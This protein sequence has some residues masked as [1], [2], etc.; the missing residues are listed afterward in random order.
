MKRQLLLVIERI[1]FSGRLFPGPP[2]HASPQPRFRQNGRRVR[3]TKTAGQPR[4]TDCLGTEPAGIFHRPNS[5]QKII[6]MALKNNRDLRLAALNV[7]RARA[8][9]GIQRAELFPGSQCGG[10]GRQTASVP[11]TL[12]APENPRTV[13]QYSV[14]LGIA[15]WEIDFF[16]RIRSL[17]DQALE[18]YL[19]TDEARR[20]A[21]ITLVSEVAR[22]YLT[23]AADR[24]N[25][26]LARSTLEAQ[27][28]AYDLIKRRYEVGVATE[29]DLAP[30]ANPSGYCP[31]RCCPLHAT[32]GAGPKRLEPS[33]RFS[34]AG[35]SSADGPGR[36]Q[37]AQGNFSRPAP[38]RHC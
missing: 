10:S 23:L 1:G 30:G 37:S 36:R 21:Q 27:Q 29:L 22:V 32:G 33:G 11:P 31:G 18:E 20:S 17:K 34:G 15:S 26:K 38:P 6:E 8:L 35:G 4:S 13:E 19:A 9:Y 25:L 5:S 24:E 16:G 12:S 28:A 14:D 7:E 3:H 2:I